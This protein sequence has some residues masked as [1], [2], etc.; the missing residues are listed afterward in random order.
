MMTFKYPLQFVALGIAF[1]LANAA[2]AQTTDKWTS[3]T[4][5]LWSTPG[6]QL[7]RA[8][9]YQHRDV[10]STTGLETSFDLIPSSVAYSL[11]FSG[12]GRRKRL[13]L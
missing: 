13:H 2:R 3:T 5:S 4:S 7:G 12:R 9:E 8:D 11:V 6:T 10:H 1:I